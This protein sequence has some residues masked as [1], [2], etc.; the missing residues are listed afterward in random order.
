MGAMNKQAVN[1]K[2]GK[3]IVSG[4]LY[5]SNEEPWSIK[6][7]L[8]GSKEFVADGSDL[9]DALINLR[10][11]LYSHGLFILCKGAHVNVYPSPMSRSMSGGLM[12][13]ELTKGQPASRKNLVNVFDEGD[14]SVVGS[15]DDQIAFY[16]EWLDSL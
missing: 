6:L 5:Y 9:F 14:E 16:K 4:F 10:K 2:Y 1:L 11:I 7:V 3:K 13:Y 12:A 15:P 8:E